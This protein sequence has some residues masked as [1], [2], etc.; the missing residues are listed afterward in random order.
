M[1]C[2]AKVMRPVMTLFHIC[3]SFDGSSIK[4]FMNE[5]IANPA[6]YASLEGELT[7]VPYGMSDNTDF[8]I[9]DDT[10][11]FYFHDAV[12]SLGLQ[13][14]YKGE[15]ELCSD[16][17]WT[18]G[19]TTSAIT[20]P[21]SLHSTDADVRFFDLQGRRISGNQRGICIRQR[22]LSDGRVINEKIIQ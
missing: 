20:Q 2:V 14:V 11:K 9:A 17:V 16:I 6:Q 21:V 18:T 1:N 8:F 3:W 10:H 4:N 13:S 7:D 15:H 19:R 22:V 12:D 5:P